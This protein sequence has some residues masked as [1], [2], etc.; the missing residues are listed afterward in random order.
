[1]Q[2]SSPTLW[3]FI[4]KCFCQLSRDKLNELYLCNFYFSIIKEF[5]DVIKGMLL[6]KNQSYLMRLINILNFFK[7]AKYLIAKTILFI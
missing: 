6:I 3:N 4:Y 1:M 5:K 7:K 2:A